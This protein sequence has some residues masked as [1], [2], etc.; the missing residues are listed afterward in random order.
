MD[1]LRKGIGAGALG[2]AVA[3]GAP[4]VASAGTVGL[5]FSPGN[6]GAVGVTS[7][8]ETNGY[9]FQDVTST[10]VVALGSWDYGISGTVSVGLWNSSGVLLASTTVNGTQTPVG[11]APRVFS[12]ISPVALTPG[13]TYYVGSLAPYIA[14][15]VN[16]VTIAPA[17]SGI[18]QCLGVLRWFGLPKQSV[19]SLLG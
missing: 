5:D 6:I 15:D 19:S 12:S 4:S 14:Y 11:S 2:L 8:A 10:S 9:A 3:A 16:P 7:G 1:A 18:G 17:D 13:D